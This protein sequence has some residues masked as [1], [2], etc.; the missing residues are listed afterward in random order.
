MINE[1]TIS[2][3]QIIQLILQFLKENNFISTYT[4]FQ[5]ETN[6][7]DNFLSS[8]L[9]NSIKEN[10]LEGNWDL[11]LTA[12]NH[13]MIPSSLLIELY[14]TIIIELMSNNEKEIA[15]CI[16]Y[17]MNSKL[18]NEL[19]TQPSFKDK[20]SFLEEVI[21]GEKTYIQYYTMKQTDKI[22]CREKIVKD[23]TEWLTPMKK[24]RL[25]YLLGQGLQNIYKM[26]K[27]NKRY[28]IYKDEFEVVEKEL[29]MFN[30][31]TDTFIKK[32]SSVEYT[33]N[34]EN[35]IE[36]FNLNKDGTFLSLGLSNGDIKLIK[37]EPKFEYIQTL[38]ANDNPIIILSFSNDSKLIASADNKKTINLFDIERKEIISSFH[39]IHS[40]VITG[41][42]FNKY[43][44]QLISSS[45]DG[46]ISIIGLLSNQLLS[47][48][49]AH[50]SFIND[51]CINLD[52]DTIYTGGSDGYVKIINTKSRVIS[53]E[54][55]LKPKGLPDT[56]EV[57]VNSIKL[58]HTNEN[59]LFCGLMSGI[60]MMIDNKG[61]TLSQY[62]SKY[63]GN[64]LSICLD[65]KWLYALDGENNL[66]TFNI[67]HE[68]MV[69]YFK[70][71]R[72][73]LILGMIHHPEKNYIV[74]FDNKQISLMV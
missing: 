39:N 58:S 32:V 36:C 49:K 1:I 67:E 17:H 74:I 33:I 53:K 70:V 61:R 2:T 13:M 64:I 35:S 52:N 15:K 26:N 54:I 7:K 37:T 9:I 48:I 30:K 18:I 28:N 14:E 12:I 38:K 41:L 4:A 22:K 55:K 71:E 63:S 47:Q 45:L 3:K 62:E 25:I 65:D 56:F 51:M 44:T 60:I 19:K 23:L 73:E 29:D 20:I 69:N 68:I 40:K 5:N 21:N 46:S 34:N 27:E 50:S 57:S 11:V 72:N 24:G 6:I 42:L 43:S 8:E 59:I 10:I 66:T 31:S 16:L